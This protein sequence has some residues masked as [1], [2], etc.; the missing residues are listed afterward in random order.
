MER[1]TIKEWTRDQLLQEVQRIRSQNQ[2]ANKNKQVIRKGTE[3]FLDTKE[4]KIRVLAYNMDDERTLPLYVNLH[5]G[6][7]VLGDPEME[8]AFMPNIAEKA[9]VKILNVDY[10]L[11]PEYP[12]PQAL[13]ECFSVIEYAKAHGDE[14]GI[15]PERIA[16][17]GQSA[18]GSLSIA[19]ALM[20]N[21]RQVLKL[22]ALVPAFDYPVTDMYTDASEKPNPEGSI[23][24]PMSQ[25]FDACYCPN[26]EERKNPLLSPVYASA[27]QIDAFPPTLIITAAHDSLCTE[28]E[29]FR[30]KLIEAGVKVTHKRFDAAHGFNIDSPGQSADESWQMIIDHLK[31]N[32]K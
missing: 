24:I 5:G 22:K 4:G 14:L 2:L 15:D 1:D 30:D 10:S 23:P 29:R 8:D 20:D 25:L 12:F 27:D 17:G 18:G 28:T 32:L 6:G 11:A 13:N 3:M 26:R 21:G 7:F 19:V 9:D 16:L 31:E